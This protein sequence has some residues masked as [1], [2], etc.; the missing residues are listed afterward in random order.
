MLVLIRTQS[1][2]SQLVIRIFYKLI[3]FRGLNV[4]WTKFYDIQSDFEVLQVLIETKMI[5]FGI[6]N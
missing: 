6:V 2:W 1:L 5:R 3:S 4:E